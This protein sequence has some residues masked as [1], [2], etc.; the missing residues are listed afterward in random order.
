M[1]DTVLGYQLATISFLLFVLLGAFDGIYFHMIKYRL[2]AHPPARFEHQLHTFRGILFIPITLIFFVWNSVGLLLWLGLLLLFIDFIAEIIDI[3]VEKAA[4]A[5]LGGISP[6]ESVI[7]ITATGFRMAALAIILVLKPSGAFAL[8][9][10]TCE[11]P[12]LPTY[13]HYIGL[14]FTIG[15]VLALLVQLSQMYFPTLGRLLVASECLLRKPQ[16]E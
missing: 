4:R 11:F 9:A 2:F 15:L 8:Q 5:Q 6:V 16:S 12:P 7:H 14:S 3:I 13:L 10:V 1:I